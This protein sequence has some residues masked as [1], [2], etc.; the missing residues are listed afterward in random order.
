MDSIRNDLSERELSGEEAQDRVQWRHLIRN[1]DP[2]Y[3]WESI[4]KKNQRGRHTAVHYDCCNFCQDNHNH[5]YL[6][7]SSYTT[8]ECLQLHYACSSKLL[9]FTQ[10]API[11]KVLRQVFHNKI[12]LHSH[13]YNTTRSFCYRTRIAV[14]VHLAWPKNAAPHNY[15]GAATGKERS[16]PK[17]VC[18]CCST[19][20]KAI[21]GSP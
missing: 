2:T 7:T 13:T 1:I 18:R 5:N 20:G 9:S 21:Y 11:K 19:Q 12:P 16:G 3:K 17:V 8:K 6:S 10:Q 15:G 14:V 4:Q